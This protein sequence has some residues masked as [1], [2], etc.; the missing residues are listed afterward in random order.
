MALGLDRRRAGRARHDPRSLPSADDRR[1][2]DACRSQPLTLEALSEQ[3]GWS[4]VDTA[5]A[6]ARL[7]HAGWLRETAGWFEAI[8]DWADL[9]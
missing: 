3:R 1:L 8:D 5:L 4:L 7:E 2:I 6:V 9:A